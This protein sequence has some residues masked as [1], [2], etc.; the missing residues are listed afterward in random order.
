MKAVVV[1]RTQTLHGIFQKGSSRTATGAAK[2]SL[3]RLTGGTGATR[4]GYR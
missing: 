2:G 3:A 1:G 4:A